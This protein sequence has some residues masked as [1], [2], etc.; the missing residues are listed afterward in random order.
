M[1]WPG[2]RCGSARSSARSA[3]RRPAE[4]AVETKHWLA[5]RAP[6]QLQLI[7]RQRRAAGRHGA[8]PRALERHHVEIAFGDD[9][10]RGFALGQHFARGFEPIE[11]A[12]FGVERALG[13]VDVFGLGVLLERAAAERDHLAASVRDFEG[14]AVAEGV[15]RALAVVAFAREAG[16][17]DFIE[18]EAL[19][20]EL[21]E[22][23]SPAAGG[24]SRCRS[25][26]RDRGPMPRAIEIS[27]CV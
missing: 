7:V 3:A 23:P 4:I 14:D 26:S 20:A 24:R 18:R 2:P 25:G 19:G 13:R 15:D 17:E 9:E 11:H 6:D 1:V 22:R 21:I 16:V 12:A 5:A 10:A 27:A 8:D